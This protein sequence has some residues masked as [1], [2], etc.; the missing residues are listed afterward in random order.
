MEQCN[1]HEIHIQEDVL[2]L[3]RHRPNQPAPLLHREQGRQRAGEARTGRHAEANPQ[4]TIR[5][6]RI[7]RKAKIETSI[8]HWKKAHFYPYIL[9]NMLFFDDSAK[10][11]L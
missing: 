7:I 2:L 6:K 3:S 4:A 1:S 10:Y 5:Q 8:H 9:R 11:F